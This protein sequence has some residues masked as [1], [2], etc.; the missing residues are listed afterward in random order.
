MG[1]LVV[2]IEVLVSPSVSLDSHELFFPFLKIYFKRERQGERVSQAGSM[3]PVQ[4]PTQS[5]IP[6][7][8][9]S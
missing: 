6:Q 7:T 1:E 9:R 8:M 5:S 4:S 2:N 3:L